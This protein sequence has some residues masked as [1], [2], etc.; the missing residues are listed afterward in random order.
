MSCYYAD[1][2]VA[3]HVRK[4]LSYFFIPATWKRFRDDIFVAWEHGTDTLPSFLDY[5]N[6]VD[7]AGKIKFTIKIADQ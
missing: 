7:E 4:V 5:L 1:I 6:N 3:Y 2:A